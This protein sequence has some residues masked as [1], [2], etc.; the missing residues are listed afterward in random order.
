MCGICGIK[1]ASSQQAGQYLERML[2]SLYHRGPDEE[3]SYYGND[4][5]CFGMRRLCII[6]LH[7]GSQPLY[8]EDRD[9]VI[10]CNGEVYNFKQLK[11][12][13]IG[14]GHHFC[15]QSD[16]EVL[17]HL[18]QE[19][20]VDCL[21]FVKGMFSFA[22]WDQRKRQL[23]MARDRFGIKPLYYYC[24]D[25]IFAFS[26][27]IK[28]LLTLPFIKKELDPHAMDL[29]FSL[30][31]VPSPFAI[32]KNIHK[33]EPAN[34]LIY[35]DKEVKITRYWDLEKTH[36]GSAVSPA[37]IQ[38][39]FR[40]LL[41]QAVKEHLVSDVPLGI[42]LSGG[43]DS[44]TLVALARK[45]F[46]GSLR[47]FSIGFEE[48]TFDE[49]RYSFLASR[50][51]QTDHHHHVFTLQDFM[52]N[53]NNVVHCLD[54]P[55]ADLSIFPTYMLSKFS[56]QNIVV[57][58]SGEGGDELF[59]GYPTYR[60]HRYM[61]FFAGL[62]YFMKKAFN[63]F[64]QSLPTS[65]RYFSL[66]FKLKQFARGLAYNDPAVRHMVWMS[67]FSDSDKE[68]MFSAEFKNHAMSNQGR[69]TEFINRFSK[70]FDTKQMHKL[71]QYIDMFT[72]LSDDLLVKA[73][74][75]SM[76]SSLEARVPYLDH[77]L[78]EFVWSVDYSLVYQKRLLKNAV[79]DIVPGEIIH[80]PKKGFPIPFSLWFANKKFFAKV[81]EFFDKDFIDKQ[82]LFDYSYVNECVKEHL[83]YK[84]DNGKKIG[85]YLMFQ[86]WYKHWYEGSV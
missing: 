24:R 81:E 74:R 47:T 8:S 29:Y 58:L 60:A 21:R 72:Y 9:I 1:G 14:K 77:A 71:I 46:R 57:A 23:F 53:F 84:K 35:A 33:L 85:T 51:F 19:Y 40:W 18:Y 7:T 67:S 42:F 43:I 65:F 36:K 52:D 56:R 26:S 41:E 79:K 54:E 68:T 12:D 48:A 80:R 86:L 75:A 22:L 61:Q 6:D 5:I 59:M 16:V 78:V 49:S 63:N 28:A 66:D 69:L 34:C 13:L 32:F 38:G 17:I 4:D 31:Y 50:Y 30:G 39:Q 82:N 55:L 62:P 2:G 70:G 15:T 83:S 10:V 20:G 37:G 45:A 76:F 44:T 11:N 27:E 73:D 3:G 64:I 25:G